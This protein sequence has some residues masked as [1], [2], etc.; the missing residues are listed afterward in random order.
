MAELFEFFKNNERVPVLVY[1]LPAIVLYL[2]GWLIKYKK[3]TWL[4][5]AYNT[6]SKKEKERYDVEKLCKYMGISFSF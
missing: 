3:V 5:S 4:I 1:V 6:A 2:L